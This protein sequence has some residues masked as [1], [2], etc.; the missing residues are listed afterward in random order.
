VTANGAAL[1]EGDGAAV[2]G[3]TSVTITAAGDAEILLFDLG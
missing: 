2:R 3:G 1:A